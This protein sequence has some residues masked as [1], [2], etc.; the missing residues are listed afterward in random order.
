MARRRERDRHTELLRP[1]R[2]SRHGPVLAGYSH[3]Q[4]TQHRLYAAPYAHPLAHAAHAG[5]RGL[6]TT[7]T[8]AHQEPERLAAR[9]A[10]HQA[11]RQTKHKPCSGRGFASPG[12]EIDNE[13]EQW[14]CLT[15]QRDLLKDVTGV[16]WRMES[17]ERGETMA[18]SE[19][20]VSKSTYAMRAT[21][22]HSTCACSCD[23]DCGCGND[24]DWGWAEGGGGVAAAFEGLP[25]NEKPAARRLWAILTSSPEA[26]ARMMVASCCWVFLSRTCTHR[27]AHTEEHAN[28]GMST[29]ASV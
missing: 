5:F 1:E 29:Q 19:G 27:N 12:T 15:S 28:T 4:H 3:N 21:V 16:D 20:R 14:Q 11:G 26:R 18:S 25:P 10:A 8:W 9:A 2:E 13:P 17:A 22:A 6:P 7:H 23:C 24:W